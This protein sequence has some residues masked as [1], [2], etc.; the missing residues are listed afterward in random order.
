MPL[1]TVEEALADLRAGKFV[2]VM[3]DEERE[4]EG[5][6]IIAAEKVTPEAIAFMATYGRGLICVA[7]PGW[8]LDELKIPLMVPEA[9]NT[10]PLGT[11]FC[12]SVEARGLVTTGISAHDRAATIRRLIDPAARP[13]D[14]LRPGHVFP[15]RARDGGV[16]V[17]PGQTEAA[18][19]LA[20]LAGL[21]PA[22][23]L[24]EIMNDDGTM[25]RRPD[26]ERFAARHGLK[27]LTVAQIIEYRRRHERL[28]ERR[29]ETRLPTRLGLFRVLGYEDLTT[30]DAH[31]VLVHGQPAADP[32]PLV[33]I[34]SA[35]LTGDVFGSRRC[36]C[37]EQLDRALAMIAAAPAGVLLYLAQEGRGIGLLNKLRAYHLQDNGLDT[38][39]A[40]LRLG[41]PADLRDYAVA[42]Q[43]LGDLG[44]QRVR[45]LTNN[46]AKV[47]A[48][49]RYGL[50][51][52]E[53]VPLQVPPNPA[54]RAYLRT[55]RE[56][57]GH[58]LDLE[59]DDGTD[60]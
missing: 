4:N 25:A 51:V 2:I 46:P 42:A 7:L 49:Q 10:S 60:V 22:G 30:G 13:E 15:L 36:D 44:V 8:R 1:A 19:D 54:N 52:V 41:F 50:T 14:F 38:V 23:V 12:V 59:D 34:H 6:L 5:D 27:L 26:L 9:A 18:V 39:E 57:L 17:R 55:K 35:C 16:L 11:A 31:L 40:N 53:R 32:A 24:C 3:D 43:M 56:K 29:V 28:V 20:R 58:Y 48:L 33:R 37:G 21:Y 47:Q 45:L